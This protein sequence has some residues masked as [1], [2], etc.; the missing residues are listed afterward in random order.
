MG[1]GTGGA[2]N[3]ATVNAN[4]IANINRGNVRASIASYAGTL[5]T[6]LRTQAQFTGAGPED[7]LGSSSIVP[8]PINTRRRTTT[9]S[10]AI[11]A[12]DSDEVPA[13]V[14]TTLTISATVP[15]PT[16]GG[17]PITVL[18]SVT[19]NSSSIYGRRLSLFFNMSIAPV[20]SLDGA[21]LQTG[22]AVEPGA[23]VTLTLSI[24]HPYPGT[25]ADQS[26][27]QD[28]QATSGGAF[29]VSNGWGPVGRAMIER[30]RQ[31]LQKNTAANPGQNFVEPVLGESLAMLGYAWLAQVART[32]QLAE[33][34]GNAVVLYQHAVGIVG[35]SPSLPPANV[36]APYVDLPFNALGVIQRTGRPQGGGPPTEQ[37]TAAL[38][39]LIHLS[40]VLESGSIEQTQPG[41]QAVSTVKLLDVASQSQKIYDFNSVGVFDALRSQL[42]N[43]DSA[44]LQR[45]RSDIGAGARII[46]HQN[47]QIQQALWKG[48][49]YFEIK[50]IGNSTRI[51]A[52][53]GGGYNGGFATTNWPPPELNSFAD[54]SVRTPSIT[55]LNTRVGISG[56]DSYGL[57]PTG[58]DPLNLVTG[59][60]FYTVD[61]ITAGNGPFPYT[62]AFQRSYDSG[63]SGAGTT[64]GP[65]WRH[66]FD[67]AVSPDSDGFEGMAATSVQAGAVSIASMFAMLDILNNAG[68]E[69]LAN[70]AVATLVAQYWMEQLTRN[71][72]R[73]ARPGA[74]ESF[75]RLSDG[76]W[77]PPIASNS[78]LSATTWEG[79][80][81]LQ[82]GDGLT[83]Q[84]TAGTPSA[85][86]RITRWASAAGARVDFTYVGGNLTTVT[87]NLNRTL[88]FAY[89]SG[90]LSSVSDGNGRSVTY[91]YVSGR[92]ERVTDPLGHVTRYTY[93]T[94]GRL[95]S[96]FYPAFPADA[97]VTNIYSDLGQVIEQRDGNGNLTTVFV[98]GRRTE[99][100]E[101]SGNRHVWYFDP[102]GKPVLEV[103][104]YGYN[105][106]NSLRLNL[107]TATVFDGQSRPATVIQP[108]GNRTVITYDRY[109]RPLTITSHPKPGSTLAPLV[110]GFAYTVPLAGRDNFRRVA[111]TT[112]PRGNVT[113]YN[114][115]NSNGN[116]RAMTQPRVTR[117]SSTTLVNPVTSYT[118]TTVGL[119]QEE[120][121]PEG[122]VTTYEYDTAG[123]LTARTGD[124]GR[125]NL[126]TTWTYDAVGNALTTVTPR[127]NVSGT[128]PAPFTTTFTYDAKR[129]LT[130]A[131]L[132]VGTR[133]GYIY[134]DDDRVIQVR[135]LIS[136]TPSVVQ[137]TFTA[138]TRTGKVLRVTDEGNVRVTYAY[139]GADRMSSATSSS[140]RRTRYFYDRLSRLTGLR[141]DVPGTLD[142]SITVNRGDV[143]RETRGYT[144]NGLLLFL[145]S[146]RTASVSDPMSFAYDGFD[147]LSRITHPPAN[148]A[149]ARFE[150]FGYD[151]NGNRTLHRTRAGRDILMNYD[152]LNRLLTRAVPPNPNAP[153]VDYTH[154]YD[155]SGR[156][157]RLGRSGDAAPI[158]Y[159]YDT[160]GRLT[161]ET[162][163]AGRA[164]TYAL[165]ADGNRVTLTWPSTGGQATFEYDGAGKVLRI[166]EAAQ[167]IVAYTYDFLPR[168]LSASYSNGVVSSWTWRLNSTLERVAHT[169]P[170]G[171][172]IV[173]FDYRYNTENAVSARLVSDATYLPGTGNPAL[174]P[175]VR[176]YAVN[177]LNQYAQVA[178]VP[179]SYDEDGNL[180]GD[181]VWT[182]GHD[183]EGRL[184]SATRPG[185]VIGF[186]YDAA[187]RRRSRA[188]NGVETQVLWSGDQE[189]AE[190]DGGGAL[191][192]RFMWGLMGP[193]EILAVI[194]VT[195]GTSARRRF[196]HAD[197]T[198]S[199]VAL[200][201]NLGV[202]LEK[203]AYT[204]FGVGN[205]N[206]GTPWRYTGRRLD[207][208]TGLYHLRARDYS[209]LLGRFIQ[210]DPIGIAGGINLYAYVENDPLNR[211]DPSGL[212]TVYLQFGG[213]LVGGLGIEGSVGVYLNTNGPL[214]IP[215][216]GVFRSI[217]FGTGAGVGLSGGI[218]VSRQF[219][220]FEG[221]A[222]TTTVQGGV[223][224]GTLNFPAP[225]PGA[226]VGSSF[227][228]GPTG[229]SVS[230]GPRSVGATLVRANTRTYGIAD[231]ATYLAGMIVG[232]SRSPAV[233]EASLSTPSSGLYIGEAAL[234]KRR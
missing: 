62:L 96:I 224:A 20:L 93:D 140:G 189:V 232:P 112:D 32:H 108:E 70:V 152:A 72:L 168:R 73:V 71:V 118:Y 129:R 67:L 144:A 210:P 98:A 179:Y 170:A 116:V 219:E 134:D 57:L 53:I 162:D 222:V 77:N 205:A 173:A 190:Y 155:L 48:F 30:H 5:V 10:Y 13:S 65:G 22:T 208:E 33:R 131:L 78:E 110:Q 14:R 230:L 113:S 54:L 217:G 209:P 38:F 178:G 146:F 125:L 195:G 141:E 159:D 216:I 166:R 228:E 212:W 91:T 128:N 83:L 63:R 194:G 18:T 1:T 84:F 221:N 139:D 109:S 177:G 121:D 36:T 92:L 103:Q 111:R 142:P 85:P 7:I 172:G 199:T 183:T 213:N 226:A 49:G 26:G 196:H 186:G 192:Q 8:L 124:A 203:H 41:L 29:I 206:G 12:T 58:G 133:T 181:G 207:A 156:L 75:V 25:N 175:G 89:T 105:A 119:L 81:T 231:L 161:A 55:P 143:L 165:D 90:R 163:A 61:D 158:I 2:L 174:A 135:R 11:E 101:P 27:T 51:G 39:T 193:D 104:D 215:D 180:T 187:G 229:G 234:Q 86:G 202:V 136:T 66:G 120:T 50:S 191:L 227:S 44:F 64:L 102:L 15:N 43:Y 37:E 151:A 200:T 164:L 117:G 138:Y 56:P 87:S 99:L 40:S 197:G 137:R 97:F 76:T 107:Q 169:L 198:G 47:G 218:G 23:F 214:G 45:R 95:Q 24:D 59:D 35:M 184:V 123:N 34:L 17:D 176:S 201:N 204:P 149:P 160:A 126:R 28:V 132:G 148:P 233:R 106:D 185:T 188:L 157:L 21:E 145:R 42:V 100:A 115:Q 150:D 31:L 127:G 3:G 211:T 88:T 68:A 225:T 220:N 6:A 167:Q 171:A 130:Q 52:I 9:L 16:P 74:V 94:G 223:V 153:A 79:P 69:P 114:V 19:L 122:R 46:M 82:T 80:Y 147:R 154:G 60:Y 182:Y 4:D